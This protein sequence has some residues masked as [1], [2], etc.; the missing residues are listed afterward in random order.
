[1]TNSH[2]VL[3]Q[4]V[5]NYIIPGKQE[6][7]VDLRLQEKRLEYVMMARLETERNVVRSYYR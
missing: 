5:Q 4:P 3:K 6:D 2:P 7:P 1:M